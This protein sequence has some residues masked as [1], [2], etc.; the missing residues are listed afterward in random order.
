MG[1][2]GGG[3]ESDSSEETKHVSPSWPPHGMDQHMLGSWHM[4]LWVNIND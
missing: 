2:G 3:V 4:P 1:G